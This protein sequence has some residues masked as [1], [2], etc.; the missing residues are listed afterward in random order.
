MSAAD[1]AARAG[2]TALAILLVLVALGVLLLRFGLARAHLVP[3]A[4]LASSILDDAKERAYEAEGRGKG[5]TLRL[6]GPE[7]AKAWDEW[8]A[9][10]RAATSA[11]FRFFGP[12]PAKAVQD[13]R[14]HAHAARAA[15]DRLQAATADGTG[16]TL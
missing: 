11:G 1:V 2:W 14:T 15:A 13:M 9:A 6:L 7:A 16:W 5:R 4:E 8:D 10:D 12:N 3:S